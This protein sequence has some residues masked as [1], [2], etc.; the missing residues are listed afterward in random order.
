M[1]FYPGKAFKTH[2]SPS[3]ALGDISSGRG[4]DRQQGQDILQHPC[5]NHRL[6]H[7]THEHLYFFNSPLWLYRSR[8]L[9]QLSNSLTAASGPVQV[10]LL[11]KKIKIMLS[12]EL[13]LQ[14]Q[15][16]AHTT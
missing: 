15:E 13:S 4:G 7:M 8:F 6:P 16:R 9:M 5:L 14:K 2:P 3:A 11:K 1:E 10:S 12:V